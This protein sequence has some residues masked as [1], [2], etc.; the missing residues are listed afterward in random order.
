MSSGDDGLFSNGKMSSEVI[1][2]TF[3]RGRRTLAYYW[4]R[5]WES[6]LIF[7]HRLFSTVIEPWEYPRAEN[8]I[9]ARDNIV[10]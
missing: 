4:I 9:P 10:T 5:I 3:N 8:S 2:S 6:V 1:G 7:N